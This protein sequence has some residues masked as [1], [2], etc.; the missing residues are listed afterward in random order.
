MLFQILVFEKSVLLFEKM[1]MIPGVY[2]LQGCSFMNEKRLI[3][4]EYQ[5]RKTFL[6]CSKKAKKGLSWMQKKKKKKEK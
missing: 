1:N 3:F 4:A 5:T 6:L 2:T